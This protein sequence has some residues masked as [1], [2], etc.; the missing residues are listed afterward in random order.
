MTPKGCLAGSR[1]D[2]H[3]EASVLASLEVVELCEHPL[4]PLCSLVWQCVKRKCFS[5]GGMTR[6]ASVAGRP[7]EQPEVYLEQSIGGAG[8]G[9]PLPCLLCCRGQPLFPFRLPSPL[10]WQRSS[11]ESLSVVLG[12]HA[13]DHCE[14]LGSVTVAGENFQDAWGGISINEGDRLVVCLPWCSV[15]PCSEDVCGFQ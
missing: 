11:V 12:D 10:A 1:E 9:A 7:F 13:F 5:R 3:G 14:L 15:F 4:W 6:P 8:M 2:R